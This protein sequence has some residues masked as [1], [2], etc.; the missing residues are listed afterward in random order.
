MLQLILTDFDG[1]LFPKGKEELSKEFMVKN[2]EL[3][4]RL[5]T[6]C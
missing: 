3:Y 1:T 5:E 2:A 6:R 4:K